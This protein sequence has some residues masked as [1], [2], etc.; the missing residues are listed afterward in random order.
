[1]S[2]PF[3]DQLQYW[4]DVASAGLGPSREG[5]VEQSK[6]QRQRKLRIQGQWGWKTSLVEILKE[7]GN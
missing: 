2:H 7:G 1:V 4:E 5:A 3:Q 6:E